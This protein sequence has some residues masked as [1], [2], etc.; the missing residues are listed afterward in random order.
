MQEVK[1]DKVNAQKMWIAVGMP[2]ALRLLAKFLP[3]LI[4]TAH[5][6]KKGN[7]K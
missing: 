5:N 3:A 1:D 2:I 6:S 4:P 7:L